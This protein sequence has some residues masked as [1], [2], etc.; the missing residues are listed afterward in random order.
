MSLYHKFPPPPDFVSDGCTIPW[1]LALLTLWML[2][3]AMRPYKAACRWHDWARRHLVHH[4]VLTVKEADWQ[5][6]AYMRDLGAP[7]W[8]RSIT[9]VVVKLTRKK[10]SRTLPVP[11]RWAQYLIPTTTQQ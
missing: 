2:P 10:Y 4:G 5:F 3:L 6:R 1:W 7:A 8:L 9:W 11:A